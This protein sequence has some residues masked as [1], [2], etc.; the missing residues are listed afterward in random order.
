MGDTIKLCQDIKY[1]GEATRCGRAGC[2]YVCYEYPVTRDVP[3]CA[4]G[5]SEADTR[6]KLRRVIDGYCAKSGLTACTHTT[7]G[8][9]YRVKT[10]LGDF[11]FD[12]GPGVDRPVVGR[13]W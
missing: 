10:S 12:H 1:Q 4:I 11:L 2:D 13:L 3:Q 6:S 9:P 7:K 5:T 8:K